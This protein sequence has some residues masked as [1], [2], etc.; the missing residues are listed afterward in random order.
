MPVNICWYFSSYPP[1]SVK[2]FLNF[3]TNQ[4]A[5]SLLILSFEPPSTNWGEAWQNRATASKVLITAD[6]AFVAVCLQ[7]KD[8][9]DGE[10]CSEGDTGL[11]L[12]HDS[13]PL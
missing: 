6:T 8:G 1:F 2:I 3:A 7:L 9:E 5:R 4:A 13:L 12:S 11:P 10:R